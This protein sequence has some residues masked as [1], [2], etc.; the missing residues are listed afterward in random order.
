MNDLAAA[1]ARFHHPLK[2]YG[3]LLGHRRADN[4]DGIRIRKGLLRSCRPAAS[5]RG[6]Q[7]G[8][9]RTVSYSGL[10]ADANHAQSSSKKFLQQ[11]ILFIVE[12]RAAEV[13][14]RRGLHQPVTLLRF[15]EAVLA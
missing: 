11:V 12:R 13:T 14:D 10:V 2:S 6:T 8:H 15:L 3:M 7:T 4:K 9:R 5:N 1:L